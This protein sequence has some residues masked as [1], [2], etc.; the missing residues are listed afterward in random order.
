MNLALTGSLQ[1][2]AGRV[3]LTL[4]LVDAAT[5]RQ[6]R[7]ETVEGRVGDL[8]SLQESAL[9]RAVGLLELALEPE[10][11]KSLAA[12]DTSQP[13]AFELYLEGRGYL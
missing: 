5:L 10:S 12:G 8:L 4:N 1:Q 6:V 7:S 2:S 9:Q 3:L 13:Q 11:L